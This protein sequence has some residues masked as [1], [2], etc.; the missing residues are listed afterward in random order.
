MT[1]GNERR[2]QP[3]IKARWPVTIITDQNTIEGRSINITTSGLFVQCGE[4]FQ[5]NEICQVIISIPDRDPILVKGNMIWSNPGGADE[6]GYRSGMGFSFIKI[7]KG[8]RQ[9]FKE[10]IADTL[11]Q[12]GGGEGGDIV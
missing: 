1:S 12:R 5:E 9:F 8:D 3:R 6:Q 4:Q 11:K 2:K 10:M 7:S